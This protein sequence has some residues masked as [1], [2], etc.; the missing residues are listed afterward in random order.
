MA[1]PYENEP[2]ASNYYLGIAWMN[3]MMKKIIH[4]KKTQR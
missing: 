4:S 2:L 3:F 1:Q